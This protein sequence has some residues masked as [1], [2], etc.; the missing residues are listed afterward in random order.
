MDVS[1]EVAAIITGCINAELIDVLMAALSNLF[2]SLNSEDVTA[3]FNLHE[4][5]PSVAL[6][7]NAIVVSEAWS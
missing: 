3:I 6:E 4:S 5:T 2:E 7:A 1:N